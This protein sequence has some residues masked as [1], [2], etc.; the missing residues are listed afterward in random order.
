[1]EL[2][3]AVLHSF[4]GYTVEHLLFTLSGNRPD[5]HLLNHLKAYKKHQRRYAIGVRIREHGEFIKR[6]YSEL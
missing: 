6:L 2:E 3:N 1:K 4:R 5:N